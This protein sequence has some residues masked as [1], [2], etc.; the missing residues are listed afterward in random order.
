MAELVRVATASLG[1]GPDSCISVEKLPEGNY[2]KVFL[3][4]LHDGRQV[5][6]KV[7]NPNAGLPFYTT[8]SEAATMEFVRTVAGIPSPKIYAWNARAAESPVGAEYIIM[9]KADGVLLSSKWPLMSTK[10]KHQLTQSIIAFERSLLAHKFENIGSIYYERDLVDSQ[11]KFPATAYSGFVVGP[12]TDRKFLEDGR[13]K[14]KTDKGPWN[15]AKE[16]ILSSARRERACIQQSIKF[17]K[18]EGIFGGPRS[19][20]PT[21]AAKLAVLD[22]F[23]K[24]ASYLLPKDSAVHIPVLWHPDLHYDNIFVDSANPAKVLSIIDWQSVHVA[25]LFQQASTPAFLEYHGPK[26][27]EG[28]SAPTLPDNFNDLSPVGKEQ[29]EILLAQQS[30]YKLYEIQSARQNPL[31]FKA[32]RYANTLGSQ[33]ISLVSQVFNDGEPI[34]KGQL[35]QLAHE[36]DQVVGKDGPPCPLRFT[37]ADIA[38]QDADQQKW[39]EGVQLM[40]DVIDALG[41]AE[42]GWQGWVSHEEYDQLKK[43]L[44]IV[45]KQ[46]VEHMAQN[47]EEREVWDRVWPFQDT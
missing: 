30:L 43:K 1:C 21:A 34:I 36:W 7:P 3:I 11:D 5:V 38:A 27:P 40:E 15:T 10:E 24:V 18:P 23:E 35:I 16:Y 28:I 14:V 33:I 47:E 17:P 25:P 32:L 44:E 12:T 29:A 13:R 46:F 20:T 41:G 6:A 19:Y 42:N 22:D 31:V 37:P 4:K 45:R 9:E 2:N 8:A 39:E 26:P